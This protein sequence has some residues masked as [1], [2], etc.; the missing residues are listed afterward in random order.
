MLPS[1][2]TT[3][4]DTTFWDRPVTAFGNVNVAWQDRTQ[5]TNPW[6]AL[7]YWQ[8]AYTI[9]NAGLGLRT[10]DERYSLSIWSK[11]LFD[12]RYIMGWSPGSSTTATTVTL[13]D[14]PRTIGGTLL[15]KLE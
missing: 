15:V 11:N 4:G 14:F 3:G 8:P 1:C 12:Q 7:Q 9:V 2:Y 6:S 10:D 13:Q 5:L